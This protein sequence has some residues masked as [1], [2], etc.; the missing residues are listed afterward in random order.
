MLLLALKKQTVMLCMPTKKAVG[1]GAAGSLQD[2]QV[3]VIS[4]SEPSA[5]SHGGIHSANNLS[6]LGSGFF[7]A[8]T[9]D[10]QT[11]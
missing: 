11:E 9:P 7:P 8:W 10:P 3:P 2:L 5:Y 4:K 1:Q 6:V